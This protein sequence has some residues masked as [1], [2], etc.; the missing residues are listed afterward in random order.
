M[1]VWLIIRAFGNAVCRP[2]PNSRKFTRPVRDGAEVLKLMLIWMHNH[3]KFDSGE[4]L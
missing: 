4:P 1:I 3:I 2:T